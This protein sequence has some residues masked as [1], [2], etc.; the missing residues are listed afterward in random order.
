M[1]DTVR[2]ALVALNVPVYH[3]TAK[4][5]SKPPYIVYA[6][7]SNIDLIA[8]GT[9]VEHAVQGSIDLF[10][11]NEGDTL[12]GSIPQALEI[13]GV[14]YYLNSVQYEEETNLIHHEWI[15]SAV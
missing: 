12:T 9:H 2:D 6:E 10:S 7:D 3:Y 4:P 15:F 13:A 11:A 8:D 14:A 5:Q 1:L